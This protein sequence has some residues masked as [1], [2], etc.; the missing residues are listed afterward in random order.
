MATKN[1]AIS[2]EAYQR[3]KALKRPG[4][5]FTDVIE[6]MTRSRGVL[7]LLG[8]LSKAEAEEAAE[9]IREG[10]EQSSRRLMHTVE[11]LS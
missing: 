10:R 3:L 5:S 2:E 7:D 6:R 1:I 11:K 8:L 9:R 4:E